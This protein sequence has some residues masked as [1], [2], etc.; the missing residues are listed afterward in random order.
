MVRIRQ[1]SMDGRKYYYLEHSQRNLGKVQKAE[2][3]IGK[4]IPGDIESL[5]QDFLLEIYEDK[6]YKTLEKIK[7][8]YRSERYGM[9][10]S[11]RTKETDNFIVK[12]T[13]NTQKMEGG[14][15]TFRETAVLLEKDIT[16]SSRPLSDVKEAEAH[17]NVF[18]EMLEHGSDL[19]LK[20]ILY[21]H[22]KMFE[23]TKSDIAG[24][25]RRH[26]VAI[27]GSK[28]VPA[29][30]VEIDLLI[31]DFLRWYNKNKTRIH[32][33][34]LAGLVH[35]KFVSI[36]PFADGNGRMGRLLL[37]FILHLNNYPMLDIK[38]RN[39]TS[40]FNA[41]ERAQVND[42]ESIFVQWV[43]RNYIKENSR[44]LS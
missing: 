25:F 20:I 22:R 30:P 12:F 18:R 21:W 11:L 10:V 32:P 28:F 35:L 34:E 15:L 42:E 41:L 2:R 36:H 27:S 13:Y 17:R 9:P 44:Y 37:N 6:W 33:V 7:K 24:R 39:R 1:R 43:F 4:S 5:K 31:K 26:Q 16:P 8:K 3:Y 23:H 38:Y 14:T 40:Y 19:T 29:L